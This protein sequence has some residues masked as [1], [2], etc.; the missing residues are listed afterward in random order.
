MS[1][2]LSPIERA[3]IGIQGWR[4]KRRAS[5]WAWH[6]WGKWKTNG[7]GNVTDGKGRVVGRYVEQSRECVD[8]GK[9]NLREDQS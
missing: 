1:S 9:I 5:C 7:Y 8:C 2:F 6:S 4:E 3:K